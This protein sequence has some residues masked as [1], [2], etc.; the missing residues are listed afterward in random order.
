MNRPS[1]LRTIATTIVL[2]SALLACKKLKGGSSEEST[3]TSS[4]TT[5][6]SGDSTGVPECD[7]YL[8]KYKACVDAN[9]P[10]VARP[11]MAEAIKKMRETYKTSAS[12]PAAK[13]GLAMGCKQALETTKQAMAQYNCTW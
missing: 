8:E 3:G 7:E 10:A 1:Q 9:V 12:N 5:T 11:G 2:V 6:A 4:G 13:A